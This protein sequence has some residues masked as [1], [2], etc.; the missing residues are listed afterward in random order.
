MTQC[1]KNGC[2]TRFEN[3]PF[4]CRSIL[5]QNLGTMVPWHTGWHYLLTTKLLPVVPISH[6]IIRYSYL[7]HATSKPPHLPICLTSTW[8]SRSDTRPRP[9]FAA[10]FVI[11][12]TIFF[13]PYSYIFHLAAPPT[14]LGLHTSTKFCTSNLNKKEFYQ[15]QLCL[16]LEFIVATIVHQKEKKN[17]WRGND[18]DQGY[19]FDRIKRRHTSK[20]SRS[21][22]A[23]KQLPRC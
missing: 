2:N 6:H 13:A 21:M 20:T 12:N 16:S 4:P 15:Y 8:V 19:L 14:T 11:Y 18:Q 1:F 9:Q 23:Q 22:Y 10:L 5:L 3:L 17:M 7:S